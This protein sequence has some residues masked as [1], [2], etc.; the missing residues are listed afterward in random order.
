MKK[1]RVGLIG[2]GMIAETAHIP[3]YLKNSDKLEIAAICDINK[4]RAAKIAESSGI[5]KAFD[6][7]KEMLEQCSLDAVSVCVTNKFHASAAVDALNAGCHVLCEKPPAMNY[8]EANAMYEAARKSGKI[9]TFNFHFRHAEETK[10]L[11][12]MIG[13]GEFGDIYAARVQALRRRG[14]PGWG[15]FVNKELQ[16]GGPLIDIGVHMLDTTLYLMGYPEPVYVAAGTHQRIGNK[17]GIGLMGSWDHTKFTVEDSAFGFIRFKSGATLNLETSF[18]LNMKEESLM[19][20]HLFGEKAGASVFPL[21]VYSET[22][23][24]LTNIDF[25]HLQSINKW[26]ESITDF[27]NSCVYD[28]QPVC[29]AE[30][31]LIIQKLIDA[32]YMSAEKGQPVIL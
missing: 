28:R 8:E 25:P 16:G 12:E 31:S 29:K 21:Q 22:G 4:D 18:A 23:A 24:V 30:E 3:A 15:N 7:H 13:R 1:I 6:S 17:P 10:A 5:P 11:K 2:A 9:L 19:N 26:E 27:I 14:I 20:V 32:M